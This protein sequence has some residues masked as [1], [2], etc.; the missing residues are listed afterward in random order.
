MAT[1]GSVIT[2]D[3]QLKK[4]FGSKIPFKKMIC[5]NTFDPAFKNIAYHEF[6]WLSVSLQTVWSSDPESRFFFLRHL[7]ASQSNN[8]YFQSDARS[9]FLYCQI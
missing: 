7:H 1:T 2:T 3:A 5:Y 6:D 4:L 9:L 8:L